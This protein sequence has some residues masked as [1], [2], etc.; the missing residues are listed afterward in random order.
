M[1]FPFSYNLQNPQNNQNA[2]AQTQNG[3]LVKNFFYNSEHY[4]WICLKKHLRWE[5]VFAETES[6]FVF[7][8]Y[9]I[10]FDHIWSFW[11]SSLSILERERKVMSKKTKN[12]FDSTGI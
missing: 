10:I 9:L 1:A 12:I 6:W 3:G 5:L 4:T 2:L 8:S 11:A 7:D